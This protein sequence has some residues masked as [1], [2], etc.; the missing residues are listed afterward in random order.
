MGGLLLGLS[1]VVGP[2][3]AVDAALRKEIDEAFSSQRDR[4]RVKAALD[5]AREA[6]A[7]VSLEARQATRESQELTDRA[8][9]VAKTVQQQQQQRD[10]K[11][12]S[13]VVGAVKN[14]R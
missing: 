8:L 2:A 3:P 9:N 10:V 4:D 6:V 13:S 1:A 7:N 12:G 5:S 14:L 11:K